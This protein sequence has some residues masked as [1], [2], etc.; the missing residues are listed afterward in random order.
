VFRSAF[1]EYLEAW[2]FRSSAELMLTLPGLD[3]RPEPVIQLLKQ[4]TAD[5]GPSPD[6]TINGQRAERRRETSELLRNLLR[7]SPLRA[8]AMWLLVR[9]TQRA[10]TYRERVRLKQA[11][12][13]TRLRRIA[14]RIGE[15]LVERGVLSARD[16]VFMLTVTE[17]AELIGGRSMFASGTRE[18]VALRRRQHERVSLL[19]PPDTFTLPHGE[20]FVS[21][22]V[23][24]PTT[25][26]TAAAVGSVLP[27]TTACGGIVTARAAVLSDVS[28]ASRLRRG[29]VLVTRQTDPGW[30]PVFCLVSGL[31]IERGG[32]LSH[33]AIIAREFGLPC[34]VG[35]KDAAHVIPHGA[36][37]TVDANRGECR[38]EAMA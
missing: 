9:W 13:Y 5:H 20:V 10:V 31:V 32:M 3:E 16:E 30:A 29:D 18:L 21:P 27:G 1:D 23:G 38:V 24:Q 14:L 28:D 26:A 4:Y 12:L 8:A 36:R 11:L 33:G 22:N 6:I 2:G 34:L 15:A 19:N 17:V 37:I 25:D 35:V 7:R